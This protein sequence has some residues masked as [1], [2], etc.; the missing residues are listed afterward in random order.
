VSPEDYTRLWG[1]I[2]FNWVY[3]LVKRG[4]NTTLHEKDVWGLSPTLQSRPIFFKFQLIQS[5]LPSY[6][7]ASSHMFGQEPYPSSSPD[8]CD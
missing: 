1:W 4:T 7:C 2:T 8:S 5:V 3:P 6:L